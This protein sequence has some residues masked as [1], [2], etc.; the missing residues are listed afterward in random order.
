MILLDTNALLWLVDDDPRLGPE[1]RRLLIQQDRVCFSA[2][3]VSE[4][5]IKH[6]LGRLTLPGSDTFPGVFSGSGLVELPFRSDHAVTLL[7]E[8]ELARHDPFDRMLLAQRQV[9]D[10][11]L[12]TSDRVLLALDRPGLLDARR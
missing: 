8:P 3:S 12:M 7:G 2:I 5:A 10:C 6:M 1:S 9:E 4:I 11:Y